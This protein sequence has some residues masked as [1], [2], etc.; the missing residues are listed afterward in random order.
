[1]ITTAISTYDFENPIYQAK[2]EGEEDYEISEELSRL[3]APEEKAI[4][5]HEEPV[6]VV[7]WVLKQT[8]KMS[9]YVPTKREV[10]SIG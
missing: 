4:Q 7:N 6:E 2:D 3:L 5:P 8:G 9:R 1:M 10:S